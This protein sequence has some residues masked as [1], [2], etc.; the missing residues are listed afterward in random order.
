MRLMGPRGINWFLSPADQLTQPA[1]AAA[2]GDAKH[3]GLPGDKPS[4]IGQ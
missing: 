1:S 3:I 2:P 4:R